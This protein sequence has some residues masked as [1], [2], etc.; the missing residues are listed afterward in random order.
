[1]QRVNAITVLFVIPY[2]NA[3]SGIPGA[4]IEEANGDTKQ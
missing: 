2:F 1:M 3:S 4:I